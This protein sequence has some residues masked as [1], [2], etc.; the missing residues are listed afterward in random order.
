MTTSIKTKLSKNFLNI[1]IIPFAVVSVILFSAFF[2]MRI[3]M[4]E[5]I[6]SIEVEKAKKV[7]HI[8]FNTEM[9]MILH[10]KTN[11]TQN[12]IDIIEQKKFPFDAKI[13]LLQNN[14]I[15]N[16]S[17]IKQHL[18]AIVNSK[19]KTFNMLIQKEVTP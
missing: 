1:T 15:S 11:I 8:L 13:V 19:K 14:H 17:L 4:F 3:F 18:D 7:L 16:D 12:Q 2:S 10:S 9:E 5:K 6:K